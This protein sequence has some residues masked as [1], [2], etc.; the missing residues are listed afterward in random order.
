MGQQAI[1]IGHGK[2]HTVLASLFCIVTALVALFGCQNRSDSVE[3]PTVAVL[4]FEATDTRE[5]M[6]DLADHLAKRFRNILSTRPEVRVI[7]S[8]SAMDHSLAGLQFAVQAEALDAD[9]LL[10][11]SLGQSEGRLQLVLRLLDRAGEELWEQGFE[12][13]LLYQ[14]QLQ[15]WAL[16]KLW[17]ELPLDPQGLEGATAFVAS[18]HYPNDATAILT[19]ARTGRRGGGPASLAMVAT[20]DIDAGLLHLAQSRFYFGQIAT[21]PPSQQPVVERLALRSLGRA[22]ENCPQHPDVELLSLIHRDE[23]DIDY[24]AEY[25]ERHPNSADL[26]LAVAELYAAEGSPSRAQPHAREASL[27]DPLGRAT[28]CRALA[29]S[30]SPVGQASD[31][32]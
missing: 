30:G 24:A 1:D 6:K 21:L 29:L 14:A 25:L 12:S 11:G 20:A 2:P 5:E 22:A 15:Q 4:P 17:P 10:A 28:R 27:L 8:G 3:R 19:L 32:P 26:Y 18:C 7:E 9:Y 31:C 23:L 16:E 13:P